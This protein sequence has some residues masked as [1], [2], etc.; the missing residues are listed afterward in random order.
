MWRDSW[1]VLLKIWAKPTVMCSFSNVCCA[2]ERS[3][4]VRAAAVGGGGAG[5][6]AGGARAVAARL[7]RP[8]ARLGPTLGRA[9]LAGYYHTPTLY[10]L[11]L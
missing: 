1:A 5:A 6:R 2:G 3:G 10:Q 7:H 9:A 8:A 11:N 4:V